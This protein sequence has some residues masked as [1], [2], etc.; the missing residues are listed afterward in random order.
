MVTIGI[1]ITANRIKNFLLGKDDE[2]TKILLE[3]YN[4]HVEEVR[5]LVGKGYAQGTLKRF[6]AALTSLERT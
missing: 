5:A 2:D 6:K 1:D 4:Q 3:V